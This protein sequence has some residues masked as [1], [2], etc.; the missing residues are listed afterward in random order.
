MHSAHSLLFCPWRPGLTTRTPPR[1]GPQRLGLATHV[2]LASHSLSCS[3]FDFFSFPWSAVWPRSVQLFSVLLCFA[4]ATHTYRVHT[5]A[6][7]TLPTSTRMHSSTHHFIFRLTDVR[8]VQKNLDYRLLA[9]HLVGRLRDRRLPLLIG[10]HQVQ[11]DGSSVGT[12]SH[13][14]LL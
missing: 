8:P 9:E 4:R 6:T 11:G 5:H 13:S 12:G 14:P 3:L 2:P 7:S 1:S 10:L